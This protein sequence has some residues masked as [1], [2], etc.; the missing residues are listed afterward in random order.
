MSRATLPHDCCSISA[1]VDDGA[2]LPLP[3]LRIASVALPA[4]VG[5]QIDRSTIAGRV[6]VY[7]FLLSGWPVNKGE[8]P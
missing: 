8:V 6:L 2:A 1:P 5:E 7:A 4:N 3:S